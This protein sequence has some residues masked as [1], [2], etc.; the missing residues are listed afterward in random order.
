MP[1][2]IYGSTLQSIK[3][4]INVKHW[5]YLI[6][7]KLES[8]YTPKYLHLFLQTKLARTFSGFFLGFF[9]FFK[10]FEIYV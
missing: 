6:E 5:L 4:C 9:F 2:N 1:T 3:Y 8:Q 10:G 7:S